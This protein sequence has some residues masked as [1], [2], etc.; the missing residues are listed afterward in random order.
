[1]NRIGDRRFLHDWQT[2]RAASQPDPESMAWAVGAVAWRRARH[3]TATADH[4][5]IMDVHHLEH[6]APAAW[7]LMVV[8]ESWWGGGR[9][10][11]CARHWASHLTGDRR[12]A[13]LW[14][15][16]EAGRRR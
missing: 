1:M 14:I 12:A 9:R 15:A 13:A 7:H 11:L 3:S 5:V 2:I 8:I 6:P 4:A 16:A 10:M